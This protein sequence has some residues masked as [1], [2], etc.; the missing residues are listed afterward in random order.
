MAKK[1]PKLHVLVRAYAS[2]LRDRAGSPLCDGAEAAAMRDIAED[3][4]HLVQ[5]RTLPTDDDRIERWEKER[6]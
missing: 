6:R 1:P 4:E 2:Q 3:L 5:R